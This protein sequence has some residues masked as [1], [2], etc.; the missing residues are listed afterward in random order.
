MD[1]SWGSVSASLNLTNDGTGGGSGPAT[2]N[3]SFGVPSSGGSHHHRSDAAASASFAGLNRHFDRLPPCLQLCLLHRTLAVL[4]GLGDGNG[5]LFVDGGGSAGRQNEKN[6]G[7]SRVD[8]ARS[9]VARG[10]GSL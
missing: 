6:S 10:G 8:A 2:N 4:I 3:L 5:L 9:A 1:K 7:S